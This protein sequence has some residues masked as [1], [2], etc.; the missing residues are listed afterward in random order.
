MHVGNWAN[1]PQ[2]DVSSLLKGTR[3]FYI[4]WLVT[5]DHGSVKYAVRRFVVKPGGYMPL[6]NHKY[7]EAVIIL[8]GKLRVK[9]NGVLYDLGPGSFFFTGPYEPHSL[10][11][12]GD[13]DAEFICVISYEDDMELRPLE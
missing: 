4:Q 7:T 11:N 8:K 1:V 2:Q 6:H 13:D 10:E 3:G 9:G 5:K 12:I